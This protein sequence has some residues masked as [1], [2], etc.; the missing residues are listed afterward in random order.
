[1]QE[2]FL[3]LSL[4]KS[5]FLSL[6]THYLRCKLLPAPLG[7][8]SSFSFWFLTT[9]ASQAACWDQGDCARETER[10]QLGSR[11]VWQLT[12]GEEVVRTEESR[13]DWHPSGRRLRLGAK[14]E[15]K[16]PRPRS[17]SRR[18]LLPPRPQ[19]PAA[20]LA[21]QGAGKE[22]PLLSPEAS[23]S[24]LAAACAFQSPENRGCGGSG[25]QMRRR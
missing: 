25:L 9:G 4:N 10:G 11:K 23:S 1:M 15:V 22:R 17:H 5:L 14:A 20:C 8:V 16:A 6:R 13:L 24:W 7:V 2:L 18:A 12:G 19:S 3:S 21:L